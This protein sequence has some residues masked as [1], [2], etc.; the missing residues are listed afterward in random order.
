MLGKKRRRRRPGRRRRSK[1]SFLKRFRHVPAVLAVVAVLS[2]IIGLYLYVEVTSR[3]ES[4]LWDFP[5]GI[6]SASLSLR[7]GEKSDLDA[8]VRRL[9]RCGYGSI[10]EEPTRPGQYR[11]TGQILEVCLRPFEAPGARFGVRWRRLEFRNGKLV[12]VHGRA[13]ETRSRVVLEPELL[14]TLHGPER[15]DRQVI[16]LEDVSPRLLKAIL[17]AEDSRFHEHSGVDLLA[18]GRAALANLSSGRIVQGG[19]TITQQTVKN[20]Y[21]GHERTWWRKFREIPMAL[22]LDMKY[23]KDRILEVYLNEVYLGQRGSEAVCGFQSASRFYFGRD[24]VDLTLSEHAVMAG[25]IRSP[26]R[27]NPFRHP[28]AALARRDQVLE[29]MVRRD[30]LTEENSRQAALQPLHLACSK[31]KD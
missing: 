12:S 1:R 31:R 29:A 20:L 10:R 5:S 2:A 22:I 28:E 13:D 24:L 3:F 7:A 19:S 14:A 8:L 27:Y 15:E 4:R 9:D 25:L 11:K 18:V 6:Y 23:S 16:L 26:G 21:L 30:W 17:A